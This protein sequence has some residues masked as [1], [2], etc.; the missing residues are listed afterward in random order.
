VITVQN[1]SLALSGLAAAALAAFIWVAIMAWN[2]GRA[3]LLLIEPRHQ[4]AAWQRGHQKPAPGQWEA[5]HEKLKQA[6]S[7]T[8]NN[9]TLHDYLAGLYALR[10]KE[11]WSDAGQRRRYFLLARSHQ[12]QS[13][14]LRETNSRT[15][16]SLAASHLALDDAQEKIDQALRQAI[17]HGPHDPATQRLVLSVLFSRWKPAPQDLRSW[18]KSKRPLLAI[19]NEFNNHHIMIPLR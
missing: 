6:L 19:M 16:A 1:K 7:F 2:M 17:L 11:R 5:A 3:E 10:G 15:W 8:P 18:A 13:L 12:E 9:P 14:G 4:I